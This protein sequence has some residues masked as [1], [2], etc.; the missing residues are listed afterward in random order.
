MVNKVVPHS[1]LY[2]E[3]ESWCQQLPDKSPRSLPIAKTVMNHGSDLDY[4]SYTE[5]VEL[6]ASTYG[7]EG[8]LEGVQAF[9]EKGPRTIAT[10]EF[11]RSRIAL[12]NLPPRE[13][14]R[15]SGGF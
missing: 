9:L 5:R 4:H 12:G 10:S 8:N 15:G 13:S 2:T 11:V 1:E 7:D 3:A 6:L 14:Q